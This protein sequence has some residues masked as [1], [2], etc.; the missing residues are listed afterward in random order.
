MIDS[1]SKTL[2]VAARY[3]EIDRPAEALA[4]LEG[5][6][7]EELETAEYW[8]I[9]SDALSGLERYAEGAEAARR[10][11]ERDPESLSL[12]NGLTLCELGLGDLDAADT[13]LRA[14][15]ELYPDHSLLL[16]NHAVVLARKG[17]L[18]AAQKAVARAMRTDPDSMPV[19]RVRAQVAVAARDPEA[20]KFVDDL[21]A[22]DP[23]D[24]L[25]HAL[26]GSLALRSKQ[27]GSAVQAYE[28]AARLDPSDQ[29]LVRNAQTARVVNHPVLAPVRPI[30]KFGRWRAYGLYISIVLALGFVGLPS[31]RLAVGG[32]WIAL[33]LLSRIGPRVLRR[34]EERKFGGF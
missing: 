7:G 24:P 8:R 28:E 26:K 18:P 16:A 34:R 1:D 3:L 23:D 15:L 31:L 25:G 14:A 11:L 9:R 30:W 13:T 5:V 12:L 22:R 10:G 6:A 4:A 27:Y 21:L 29:T 17:D 2:L 33:V 20:P 32:I 19:R